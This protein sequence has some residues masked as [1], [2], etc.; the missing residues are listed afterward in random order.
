[1]NKFNVVFTIFLN[2]MKLLIES[3][4]ILNMDMDVDVDICNVTGEQ[5]RRCIKKKAKRNVSHAGCQ[6]LYCNWRQ[7]MNDRCKNKKPEWA[8]RKRTKYDRMKVV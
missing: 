5:P 1:M 2:N 3:P 6:P 7:F 8:D 4:F